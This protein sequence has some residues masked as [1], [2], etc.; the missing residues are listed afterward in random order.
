VT[1]VFLPE[2]RAEYSLATDTAKTRRVGLPTF[3]VRKPVWPRLLRPQDAKRDFSPRRSAVRA[4]SAGVSSS[5]QIAFLR[6]LAVCS[7]TTVTSMGPIAERL[8]PPADVRRLCA[9][10]EPEPSAGVSVSEDVASLLES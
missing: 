4:G 10:E 9:V 7:G 1:V 5:V 6:C 2:R 8:V 3:P